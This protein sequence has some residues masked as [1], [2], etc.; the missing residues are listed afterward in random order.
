[1]KKR[2]DNS[3]AEGEVT[4]HAHRVTGLDVAVFGD[5]VDRE[6]SAPNGA[7]VSHEEH[8]QYTLPPNE[9]DITR[10][11]ELDPDTDDTRAVAD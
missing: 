6:L 11:R 2:M 5:G 10:Q 4:G 8:K 9:Y 1:M 3:L 7:D